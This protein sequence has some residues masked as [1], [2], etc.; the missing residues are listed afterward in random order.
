MDL[1]KKF[2]KDNEYEE[3]ISHIKNIAELI[4]NYLL[5]IL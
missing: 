1:I 4:K 5:L 3:I 2:Q